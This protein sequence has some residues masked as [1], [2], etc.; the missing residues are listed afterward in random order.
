MDMLVHCS[1]C[2]TP[3][4][5]PASASGHRAR[6][7]ACKVTF[8]VPKPTDLFEETVST[9]IEQDL[10]LLPTQVDEEQP[11]VPSDA[12]AAG[13]GTGDLTKGA[14]WPSDDAGGSAAGVTVLA[15]AVS[16]L[17]P[18]PPP[19]P[20]LEERLGLTDL[21]EPTTASRPEPGTDK[22][23]AKPRHRSGLP[24]LSTGS[25]RVY[26][27]RKPAPPPPPRDDSPSARAKP[28][29]P[30]RVTEGLIGTRPPVSND[31]AAAAA[32]AHGSSPT[33]DAP[34]FAKLGPTPLTY[35][36]GLT[37]D[38]VAPHLVVTRTSHAGVTL[39]FDA[40]WLTHD[41]FRAAMPV[42]CAFCGRAKR[43][44]L[45]ARPVIFEDRALSDRKTLDQAVASLEHRVLGERSP[46]QIVAMM[47]DV[48]H[49]PPPFQ[50][51]MPWYVSNRYAHLTLHTVTR[52]RT[53]GG[54]TCEVLIPDAHTALAFLANVNGVCG[55]EY[56]LLEREV[57]LL[58]GDAWQA[59]SDAVRQRLEFWCK[60][61]PA[62]QFK[63]FL[64]DADFGKRDEGLGGLVLTDQRLIFCKYHH[65]GQ[66]RLEDEATVHVHVKSHVASLT[67]HTGND[68]MRMVKVAADDLP[69]L[70][71][72]I[73]QAP[74]L[75]YE[76]VTDEP[77][78]TV[79]AT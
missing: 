41:G 20:S 18:P 2:R 9:W 44:E 57:S 34:A 63:L 43:D 68:R 71:E 13:G 53:D 21:V 55:P 62:E 28:E 60:L 61:F 7:P 47:Q 52:N 10:G 56:E 51:P 6:C 76:L 32:P 78:P 26:W 70:L 12:A 23:D 54:V 15:A 42:R 77:I 50:L 22:A 1:G 33:V 3:L 30:F 25:G 73:T 66:V 40:V 65:R 4:R 14:A 35:P 58:H 46:R 59:M 5:V 16:P 48:P 36:T 79:D 67:L 17:A 69:K 64:P 27:Q 49:L 75:R 39:A 72:A 45:I 8:V 19:P 31:P 24:K 74:T 38:P 37:R 11:G 29:A